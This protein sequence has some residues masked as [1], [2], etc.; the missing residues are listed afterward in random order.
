[1]KAHLEI[2]FLDLVVDLTGVVAL[3]IVQEVGLPSVGRDG[4]VAVSLDVVLN[5]WQEDV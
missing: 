2:D 3:E 1:M 5:V 4:A